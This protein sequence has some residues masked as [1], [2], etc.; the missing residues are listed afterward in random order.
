MEPLERDVTGP[1]CFVSLT[2]ANMCYTLCDVGN[3]GRLDLDG[4]GVNY[5]QHLCI[6]EEPNSTISASTSAA[7]QLCKRAR[8]RARLASA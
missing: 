3:G 7:F 1:I 5:R 6:L 2:L 8:M 4:L